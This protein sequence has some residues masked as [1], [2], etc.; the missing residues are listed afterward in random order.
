MVGFR[1]FDV[2]LLIL[3][4]VWFFRL[5]DD[6]SDTPPEDDEGGGGGGPERN[7][8]K[9]P[10]AVVSSC[11]TDRCPMDAAGC[12]T[13]IARRAPAGA[14]RLDRCPARCPRECDRRARPSG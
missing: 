11:P 12:A 7:P 14:A 13:A 5:R 6:G 1:V 2:G 9:G 4:L 3:W 10:G 8:E